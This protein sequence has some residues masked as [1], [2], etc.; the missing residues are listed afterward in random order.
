MVNKVIEEVTDAHVVAALESNIAIIRFDLNRDVAYV[1]DIFAQAV[2][3]E[4]SELLG[5]NHKILCFPEFLKSSSYEKLWRDLLQ[6]KSFQ[7][8]IERKDKLNHSVWLEAT[9]MPV[10]S[11]DGRK[12]ISIIKVATNISER[13]HSLTLV[14]DELKSMAEQLSKRSEIGIQRSDELLVSIRKIAEDSNENFNML[15]ILQINAENIYKIVQTVRDI[16]A[17]TNLL[18]L[19]AAIEAARA[20]E[21]GRGF[22]VVAKEVRK[23]SSRVED[24]IVEIRSGV[25]SI[26]NEVKKIAVGTNRTKEKSE[27]CLEQIQVAMNDFTEIA[28]AAAQLDEK[29]KKVSEII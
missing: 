3:Y 23:L 7:D 22:D 27:R 25:E 18:A 14:I 24:S 15:G 29:S 13:Q 4:K 2:G 17:Q 1:N 20:G 6:G 21:Y 8:K 19:N 28:S 26:S 5:K 10:F 9:Y 12:V 11:N 16:A